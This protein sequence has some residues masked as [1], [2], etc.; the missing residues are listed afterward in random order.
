VPETGAPSKI[1]AIPAYTQVAELQ[2]EVVELHPGVV[3]F[4]LDLAITLLHLVRKHLVVDQPKEALRYAQEGTERLE[5]LLVTD[6]DP[7][8]QARS[9][10]GTTWQ[11]RAE[12]LVAL[13]RDNE[14]VEALLAAIRHQSKA[15]EQ[16]PRSDDYREQLFNHHFHLAVLRCILGQ[17][18]EA[19]SSLEAMEPLWPANAGNLF[20]DAQELARGWNKATG[21]KGGRTERTGTATQLYGALVV[22][23][24]ERSV[25]AGFRDFS[26]LI[27]DPAFEAFRA[28][29]DFQRLLMRTMDLAFPIAPLAR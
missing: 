22:T 21:A 25:K 13:G 27:D 11:K 24:L 4:R 19:A 8:G 20:S 12:A 10:L 16:D 2:R 7:L 29:D 1:R 18:N 14:A 15:L 23:M 3:R 17:T 9:L 5:A 26:R 6:R 28:R